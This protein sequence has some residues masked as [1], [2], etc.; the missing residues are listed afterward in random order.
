MIFQSSLAEDIE[1]IDFQFLKNQE[2]VEKKEIII[3]GFLKKGLNNNFVLSANP[4]TKSCCV[5][6]KEN[7]AKEIALEGSFPENLINKVVKIRGFLSIL[8]NQKK[9]DLPVIIHNNSKSYLTYF[10][11]SIT[12]IVIIFKFSK[13][14]FR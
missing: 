1:E 10:V 8:D 11:F 4:E 6:K 3:K 5:G 9:I 7:Q 2:C 12:I 13:K 14:L